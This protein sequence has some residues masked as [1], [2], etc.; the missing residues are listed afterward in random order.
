[1]LSHHINVHHSEHTK[2]MN[3][4]RVLKTRWCSASSGG[5]TAVHMTNAHLATT[6]QGQQHVHGVQPWSVRIQPDVGRLPRCASHAQL[7]RPSSLY[8]LDCC[9]KNLSTRSHDDQNAN[10]RIDTINFMILLIYSQQDCHTLHHFGRAAS[11]PCFQLQRLTGSQMHTHQCCCL[12]ENQK[13]SPAEHCQ[14]NILV[15]L[16]ISFCPYVLQSTEKL[17]CGL[18]QPFGARLHD[19]AHQRPAGAGAVPPQAAELDGEAAGV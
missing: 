4:G 11:C 14:R 13:N 1:M 3:R 6:L 12:S 9:H 19:P 15:S 8:P 7:V 10:L 16:G 18:L 5:N 17:W 2:G